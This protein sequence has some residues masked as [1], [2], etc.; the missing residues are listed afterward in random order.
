M[1]ISHLLFQVRSIHGEPADELSREAHARDAHMV[2]LPPANRAIP[3]GKIAKNII[4][5]DTSP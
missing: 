3:S 1:Y 4:Q 5:G 2:P